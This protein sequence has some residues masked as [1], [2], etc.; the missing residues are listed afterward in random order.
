MKGEQQRC[1]HGLSEVNFP[2]DLEVQQQ[3]ETQNREHCTPT[4]SS[5]V[6]IKSRYLFTF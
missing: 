1:T 2:L 3:V 5:T 6:A 4:Y